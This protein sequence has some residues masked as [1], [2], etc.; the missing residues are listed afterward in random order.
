MAA[1]VK[2][3][4]TAEFADEVLDRSGTVPVVVD[5]WAE[6]CGPCKVLGPVLERLAGEDGAAWELAKVDVDANPRLA[7]QYGVQ[8]IPTVVAFKDGQPVARFTGAVPEAQVREFLGGLAPS[9]LDLMTSAGYA[10][11]ERGD[12]TEASRTWASVLEND[13]AHD[14]AGTALAGLLLERGEPE[15][16]LS[17][18]GRLAPTEAVRRLQAAA[19]LTGGGDLD[20]LAAAAQDGSPGSLV[21]YGRA[22]AAQGAHEQALDTLL[23]AVA[24]RDEAHSDDAR[25]IVLDIFELLG[26]GHPL[27]S[28]YRR[29]LASALF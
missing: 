14:G 5:F 17:I 28:T 20:G 4:S 2:D 13:P 19:R 27:T 3:V 25:K 26:P 1:N 24:T 6:W 23:E 22:L 15:T 10:A 9:E 21:A 11:L 12:E 29:R 16:A 18:L 8:G 7:G